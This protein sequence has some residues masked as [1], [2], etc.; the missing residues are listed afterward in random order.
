MGTQIIYLSLRLSKKTRF[1]APAGGLSGT[2]D[3]GDAT[4]QGRPGVGDTLRHD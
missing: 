4:P 1:G 2:A 3:G